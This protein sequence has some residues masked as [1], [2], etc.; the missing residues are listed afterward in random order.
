MNSRGRFLIVSWDGG[1]NAPPALNLGARLTNLGHRVRLLGW[2]S[3]ATGAAAAG[4][5]FATYPSVPAWPPDLAFEDAMNDRLA[6]ALCSP[7][8]RG[9]VLAEAR[10]FAPDVVVV[11]CMMG[12]G[13]EAAHELGH[14]H[15]VLV[16]LPYFAFMHERGDA[17][18]RATRARLVGAADAVLALVPPGFDTPCEV[19]ANT[20]YV[21]P[22]TDPNPGEPLGRVDADLLAAPGDPWVLLSLSSTLQGQAHALPTMLEALGSLPVRVLLTLGGVLPTSAVDAPPNVTV[23]EFVRHALVLPHMAAVVSHGGLSTITSALAFGVPLVCIPQ[24]RDQSINAER[25]A[26]TG[27]GRALR[28]D[29]PPAAIASA[30]RELLADSGARREASRFADI[31]ATLGR[32]ATAVTQ[33]ARLH[34]RPG[35]SQSGCRTSTVG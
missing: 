20:S 24:G 32:G 3:M 30:V 13:L 9:D 25:V 15:A 10:D 34:A 14:P 27:V 7:Q 29:A 19:P 28:V 11:D 22:I 16:H 17:V 4:L 33:V 26:A 12:A 5:E 18:S 21:G 2:D 8:T 6:P 1:G 31:I 35:H 23:R